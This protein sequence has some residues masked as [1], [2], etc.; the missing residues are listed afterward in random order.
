MEKED[1][2]TNFVPE[3]ATRPRHSVHTRV[4]PGNICA[5]DSRKGCAEGPV[6]RD[7]AVEQL[8]RG[9]VGKGEVLG[10]LRV[11][12]QRVKSAQEAG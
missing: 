11:P 1:G 9:G 5:H 7:F 2:F 8:R 10:W 4:Q 3:G 6:E 12:L